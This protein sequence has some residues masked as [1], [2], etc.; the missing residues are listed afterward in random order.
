MKTVQFDRVLA[1]YPHARGFAYVV[2]DG[3]NIPADWGMSDR[4]RDRAPVSIAEQLGGLLD[5]SCPRILVLRRLTTSTGA[6]RSVE[7]LRIMID[8]ARRKNIAT[9]MIS[10]ENIQETFEH[11]LSP[12]REMIARDIAAR[13]PT[14]AAF[15]PE[16][17]KIWN[18]EDRRM[19]LFDAAALGLTHFATSSGS[20]RA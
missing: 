13:I 1:F 16:P 19:G 17:R 20:N 15:L 14:L 4:R 10:R 8:L 12:T 18:G 11:L 9:G 6:R 3:P 2:F 5:E 7:L